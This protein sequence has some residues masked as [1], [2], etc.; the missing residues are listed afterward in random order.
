VELDWL[1]VVVVV[2]V[3][4][5]DEVDEEEREDRLPLE[6]ALDDSRGPEVDDDIVEEIETVELL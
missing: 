6:K 1:S 3:P 4:P 5:R 2:A